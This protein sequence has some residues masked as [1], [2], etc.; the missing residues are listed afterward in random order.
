MG[1]KE[2]CGGVGVGWT[3]RKDSPDNKQFFIDV[4]S[5]VLHLLKNS[6]G[7]GGG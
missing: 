2:G 1:Q 5:I 4:L 6:F 7:R 3:K